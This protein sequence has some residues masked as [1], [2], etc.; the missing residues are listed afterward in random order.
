MPREHTVAVRLKAEQGAVTHC[1]GHQYHISIRPGEELA[2][3]GDGSPITRAE[4][5]LIL[6]PT[7]HFEV[8]NNEN[9]SAAQE[10]SE[11]EE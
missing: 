7:G 2:K 4:F 8:V 5:D 6:A 10:G 11:K 9:E 3:W 1:A